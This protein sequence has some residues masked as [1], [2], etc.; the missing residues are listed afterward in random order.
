MQHVYDTLTMYLVLLFIVMLKTKV[1]KCKQKYP[2]SSFIM[3]LEIT[4]IWVQQGQTTHNG[5]LDII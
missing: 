2:T 5:T 1:Q 4:F 3:I